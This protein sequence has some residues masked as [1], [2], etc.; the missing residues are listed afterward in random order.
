M[1]YDYYQ[2]TPCE[3]DELISRGICPV[4]PT[5]SS[6]HEVILIY[7]RELA[8]YLIQLKKMGA[9]N[10]VIKEHII[11]AI[12]GIITNVDYNQIQFQQLLSGLSVDLSQA[13][14]LYDNLSA[15]NK[16]EAKYLKSIFKSGQKFDIAE[17]IKKGEK[18]YIQR[19]A[20]SS[21]EQK[22]L[23]DIMFFLI[24][25][26]CIRIIQIR[27]YKKD[28]TKAYD[29]ILVLLNTMNSENI[30]S[31]NA[32]TIIEQ[33]TTEYYNIVKELSF[34][35]EEAHGERKS[36]YIQ[37][38]PRNGKAILVSGVDMTHLEAVLEATK[39]RGVDVYTHGITLLM[40][41]TLAKFRKY[42]NLVGHFGKG[43][44]NSLFDFAAFPGA[45]LVT[46]YLFQKV[47]YLY[48]GRIFTTDS[49]APRGIVKIKNNDYE[50][51]INAALE[52]K[53]FTKKQQ[54][55]ILRVGFR[56]KELEEKVQVIIDKMEKN[57]I[58]H[59][60][61]IGLLNYTNDY[62]NYF[63]KFLELMPADCYALSLAYDQNAENILH[64]D[65]FYDYLFIYKVLEKINEK[66][67]LDQLKI[68]IFITKCDQ[69]TIANVIN[70]INMGIK[71]IFL[72]KCIP[73]L[74]NPSMVS[75]MRKT[76]GINEFSKPEDDL[77]K[78]LSE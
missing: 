41:H 16:Y 52:C 39:N 47:E 38:A 19:N 40:A 30:D 9:N 55:S 75:T 62:K 45:I 68:T 8:Y 21:F 32:K 48:R 72:C 74:I 1:Y 15:K 17:I 31:E 18:F 56:Q 11:E 12:S 44:D 42:P 59:L 6:L 25:N 5:F 37:F 60:Y 7:L 43:A 49:Y 70:F 46:K 4:N 35:Q 53:G 63:Q 10:E 61:I 66:K 14:K 65:S 50:P 64:V 58:K 78:T 27:S 26:L 71:S 13:K 28:Y 73:S 34:A 23:F 29:A 69:Y 33:C 24:K 57:E 36:V 76:F 67:P 22:N 54:E 77:A 2:S 20:D 51:L 3:Y